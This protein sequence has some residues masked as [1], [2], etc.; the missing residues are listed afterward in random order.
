MRQHLPWPPRR[1]NGQLSVHP[2]EAKINEFHDAVRSRVEFMV[3]TV[4]GSTLLR[5]LVHDMR[6]VCSQ[7]STSRSAWV[8]VLKKYKL[9]YSMLVDRARSTSSIKFLN[10]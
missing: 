3:E 2:H 5:D 1:K 10:R 9:V 7:E 6:Q 8:L 4:L